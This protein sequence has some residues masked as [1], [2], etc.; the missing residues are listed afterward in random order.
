MKKLFYFFLLLLINRCY[1]CAFS[2]AEL[3]TVIDSLQK[4]DRS[5]LEQSLITQFQNLPVKELQT[6]AQQLSPENQKQISQILFKYFP[7]EFER[8][9]TSSDFSQAQKLLELHLAFSYLSGME[10]LI[11]SH[12]ARYAYTFFQSDKIDRSGRN[13]ILNLLKQKFIPPIPENYIDFNGN[14]KKPIT[15]FS[16]ALLFNYFV[17]LVMETSLLD[18]PLEERNVYFRNKIQMI[19]DQLGIQTYDARIIP[20]DTTFPNMIPKHDEAFWL[21]QDPTGF[22]VAAGETLIYCAQGTQLKEWPLQ[23]NRP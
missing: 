4:K 6:L 2:T 21:L 19:S 16:Q 23:R 14:S 22:F 13:A 18:L 7:H 11:Q 20:Q 15:F 5:V 12:T 8:S 9:Y 10:Y 3:Q 1:L 17:T